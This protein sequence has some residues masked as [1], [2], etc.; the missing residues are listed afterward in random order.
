VA[1]LRYSKGTDEAT[2]TG[3]ELA[4]VIPLINNEPRL[5]IWLDHLNYEGNT[6]HAL[7][8]RMCRGVRSTLSHSLLYLKCTRPLGI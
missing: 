6:K 3:L 1:V 4:V 8:K 5:P 2:D 7:G